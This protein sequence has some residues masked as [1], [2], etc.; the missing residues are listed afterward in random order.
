MPS[1]DWLNTTPNSL[2]P[3]EKSRISRLKRPGTN[4][5]TPPALLTTRQL[6]GRPSKVG[7]KRDS[8]LWS[9]YESGEVPH[10]F[11]G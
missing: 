7:C 4:E 9:K 2:P 5:C 1:P 11:T 6:F 3:I 8:K 10:D